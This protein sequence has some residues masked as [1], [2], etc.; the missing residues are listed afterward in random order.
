MALLLPA[1]ESPCSTMLVERDREEASALDLWREVLRD[2][3]SLR[4]MEQ[5]VDRALSEPAR[6]D[7]TTSS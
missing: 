1:P 2:I 5:A 4:A 6:G 7:G 3:G